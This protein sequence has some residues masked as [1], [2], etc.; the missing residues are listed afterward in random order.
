MSELC[1]RCR[2]FP[3]VC[4]SGWC[5]Q[6]ERGRQGPQGPQGVQGPPGVSP[7]GDGVSGFGPPSPVPVA[8][9]TPPDGTLTF[10]G[11]LESPFGDDK[12]VAFAVVTV[13]LLVSFVDTTG[14]LT[15]SV[16]Y[17]AQNGVLAFRTIGVVNLTDASPPEISGVLC[18]DDVQSWP[19]FFEIE[20]V[21]AGSTGGYVAIAYTSFF[22]VSRRF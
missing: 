6:I 21:I 2:S 8:M 18:F 12:P 1:Q 19:T 20:F 16:R 17:Q 5:A 3:C 22:T 11:Y 14:T 9:T 13:S 7:P 4:G 10:F 15:I